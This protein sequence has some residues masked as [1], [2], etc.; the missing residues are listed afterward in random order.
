MKKPENFE[1]KKWLCENTI[2]GL[3]MSQS[4]TS[5]DTWDTYWLLKAGNGAIKRIKDTTIEQLVIV[6]P[7][8]VAVMRVRPAVL[9]EVEEWKKFAAKESFDLKEF[10]RLKIKFG[11]KNE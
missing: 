6:K 7:D 4:M 10:E 8:W 2:I 9:K 1:L 11:E 3:T 5:E